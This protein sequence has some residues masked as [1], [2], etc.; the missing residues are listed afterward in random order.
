MLQNP[1]FAMFERD[2]ASGS[3]V[4]VEFATANDVWALTAVI[5]SIAIGAAMSASITILTI[6]YLRTKLRER[7][8]PLLCHCLMLRCATHTTLRCRTPF[9]NDLPLSGS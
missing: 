7:Q 2:Y 9:R 3:Y 4:P 5:L 1:H 6:V 8:V